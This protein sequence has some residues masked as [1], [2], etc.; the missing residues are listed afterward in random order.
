MNAAQYSAVVR[1]A[2]VLWMFTRCAPGTSSD[3]DVAVVDS[4]S[5]RI[6]TI[7]MDRWPLSEWS[8]DPTPLATIT[9]RRPD[10]S[11]GFGLVGPV[12][13]LSDG[14]IA[15]ADVSESRVLLFDASGRFERAFGKRGDGPGESRRIQTLEPGPGDT[16]GTFDAALRRLSFWHPAVGFIRSVS[17]AGGGGLDAWPEAAWWWRDSLIVVLQVR[18]TPREAL[19]PGIGVRRWPTLA[20]LTLRDLAGNVLRSSPEFAGTYSGLVES[21]DVRL[22][23]ANRP[24]VAVHDAGVCYGSGSAYS[25]DCLDST[26][27]LRTSI[28]WPGA[29]EPL[30]VGEVDSVRRAARAL[31]A[32]S[33]SPQRAA[34][35]FA[36]SFADEVLPDFRPSIGRLFTDLNGSFWVERFEPIM[37]GASTRPSGRTWTVLR[38]D[39]VP[40]GRL[41]MAASARLESVRDSLAL[42]VRSDSLELER[43]FVMRLR[44]P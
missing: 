19:P 3:P 41:S 27:A 37:L 15:I 12:R 33:V 39:G 1:A 25:I 30:T 6:T 32:T 17:L 11:T 42:V 22:P 38:R 44:R 40:V 16:I 7:T 5:V 43:V 29:R 28:R 20:H 2:A 10:D 9:G 26:F 21:G 31:A 14:R 34:S 23:F 36:P 8:L 18:A 4:G 13:F 35:A 24:F